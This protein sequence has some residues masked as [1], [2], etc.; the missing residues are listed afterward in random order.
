MAIKP[1]TGAVPVKNYIS[2]SH[3]HSDVDHEVYKPQNRASGLKRVSVICLFALSPLGAEALTPVIID[4]VSP[5]V[6]M[7]KQSGNRAFQCYK[8]TKVLG[9]Q[10]ITYYGYSSDDNPNTME[11]LQF[12]YQNRVGNG[13]GEFKGMF[14]AIYPVETNGRYLIAFKKADKGVLSQSLSLCLIPKELGEIIAMMSNSSK[15][16]EALVRASK[17]DLIE[18]LGEKAVQTAPYIEDIPMTYTPLSSSR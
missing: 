5:K 8:N 18:I 15:N 10:R 12:V 16:N 11:K 7:V 6:E 9:N 13:I 17:E 4:L 1:I 14:V 3:R 2:F